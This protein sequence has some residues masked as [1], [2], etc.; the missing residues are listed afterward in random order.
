LHKW[1]ESRNHMNSLI[2]ATDSRSTLRSIHERFQI[3]WIVVPWPRFDS[4]RNSP[5]DSSAHS[6]MQSNP[7][8]FRTFSK[9]KPRPLSL[10]II[11]TVLPFLRGKGEQILLHYTWRYW[12]RLLANINHYTIFPTQRW[13]S[14]DPRSCLKSVFSYPNSY[15]TGVTVDIQPI[16]YHQEALL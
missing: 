16:F 9:S 5:P 3:A 11:S 1:K 12:K 15:C 4:T 10:I 13:D 14:T 8:P 6:W 2:N 7:N